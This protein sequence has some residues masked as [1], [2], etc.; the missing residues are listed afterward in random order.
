MDGGRALGGRA[1]V[2]YQ[3]FDV[4]RS[5]ARCCIFFGGAVSVSSFQEQEWGDG[6]GRR[7]IA[8]T[9]GVVMHHREMRRRRGDATPRRKEGREGGA[10]LKSRI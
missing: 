2:I 3:E 6:R 5:L 10:T 4:G 7:A 9:I 1:G 8:A